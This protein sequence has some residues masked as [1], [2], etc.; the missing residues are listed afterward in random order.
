MVEGNKH[1]LAVQI[2][3]RKT[4]RRDFLARWNDFFA[5]L[6]YLSDSNMYTLPVAV[7]FFQGLYSAN[8]GPLM[9]MACV[10]I[11]PVMLLFLFAQR[12]FVQGVATTGIKGG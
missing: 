4:S 8:L 1:D 5:P 10:T 7:R 2:I 3:E 11:L 6:I 12:M 9:A